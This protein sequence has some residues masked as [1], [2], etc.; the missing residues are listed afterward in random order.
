MLIK[1]I[2]VLCIFYVIWELEALK[3]MLGSTSIG[4]MNK[5]L[6]H[7]HEHFWQFLTRKMM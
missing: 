1:V 5:I 3:K 6:F 4:L 7:G 2:P